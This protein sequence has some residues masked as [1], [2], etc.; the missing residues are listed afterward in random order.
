MFSR[1]AALLMVD[2]QRGFVNAWTSLAPA[3]VEKLQNEYQT[4]FATRFVNSDPLN[5]RRLIRVGS[6]CCEYGGC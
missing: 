3:A 2:V 6:F 5:Y 4:V 1:D